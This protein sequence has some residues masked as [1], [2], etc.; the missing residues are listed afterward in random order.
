MDTNPRT[1]SFAPRRARGL[2]W[3]PVR[4]LHPGHQPKLQ[5]H[6]LALDDDDRVWRFGHHASNAHIERY[7]EQLDFQR[8][9]FFGIFDRR[10]TLLALGHLA[11]QPTGGVAEFA[12]SV[13]PRARGRGLGGRMFEHAARQARNLGVHTLQLLLAR[14][15]T[16]MLA[17]VQRAGAL[18]D[19]DGA[20]ARAELPLA[21]NTLGSRIEEL[22]GEQAA[23]IDF[24]IKRHALRLDTLLPGDATT[25]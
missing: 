16:P 15:N 21:G 14:D 11:L 3:V 1:T 9:R 23:K 7:V 18:I 5:A 19:F 24:R 6:L 22:L 10:L 17:I 4:R 25:S 20:D 13:L 2:L 12:V 8:D